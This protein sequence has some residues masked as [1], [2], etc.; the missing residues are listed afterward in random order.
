MTYLAY[1]LKLTHVIDEFSC[2]EAVIDCLETA[3]TLLLI[4]WI[5]N[6]SFTIRK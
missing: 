6:I 3:K 5:V 1:E 2:I 4:K